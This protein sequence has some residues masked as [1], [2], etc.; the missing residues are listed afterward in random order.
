MHHTTLSALLQS[1]KAKHQRLAVSADTAGEELEN[2]AGEN[3][4][5]SR[6][7]KHDESSD[8]ETD[9]YNISNDKYYNQQRSNK[10]RQK[11]SRTRIIHSEPALKLS[12]V[13]SHHTP[14][15]WQ[16]FHRPKTK[17]PINENHSV[18]PLLIEDSSQ[19]KIELRHKS[20]LSATDGRIVLM[21]YIEERPLMFNNLGMGSKVR[22]YYRKRN[23]NENPLL[24]F[25]DGENVLLDETDE[26]PF[27]GDIAAGRTVQALDNNLFRAPIF[28][29]TTPETDFLVIRKGG[30]LYL[31]EIPT[32]YTVGQLQPKMEVPTPNS[33]AANNFVKNR[34]S[35][36]IYR[37]YLKD[38]NVAIKISDLMTLFPGNSETAIR[39]RLKDCAGFQRGGGD[40]GAWVIK[41][42]SQLPSEEEL[43][44]IITPENVCLY[45]SMLLGQYYLEQ[46]GVRYFT[47]I[48]PAFT[49]ALQQ[50]E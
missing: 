48:S 16:E 23:T 7:K 47:S 39:K 49:Q 12:L 18:T 34:L 31:R 4:A 28:K 2:E 41:D 43:K 45:E 15:Q 8:L 24:R 27:L 44:T 25:E 6:R 17:I 13:R 30:K 1:Q 36:Y 19:N 21:E 38:P 3:E 50:I 37:L 9:K 20:D 40:T 14:A 42:Q 5:K 35:A 29:H 26:S 32:V 33:R 22:N 10:V 11:L 46:A